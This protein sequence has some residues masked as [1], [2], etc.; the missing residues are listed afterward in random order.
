MAP[1]GFED[2]S[3]ASIEKAV[4]RRLRLLYVGMELPSKA[5]NDFIPTKEERNREIYRRYIEGARAVDLASEYEISLQRVYMV[6][7][8]GRRNQW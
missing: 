4:R 5:I 1:E 3:S 8:M 6:I 2:S 7:R